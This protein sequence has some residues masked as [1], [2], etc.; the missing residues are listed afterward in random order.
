MMKNL[1]TYITGDVLVKGTAFLTLPLYS[2]L[3]MPSEYGVLGLLN[4]LVA[5]LPVVLTFGYINAFVRFFFESQERTIISTFVY[6]GLLLN[7]FY[8]LVSMI[9]YQLIVY[10]FDINLLHFMLKVL[11]S[12]VVFIFHILLL[13]YRSKSLASAFMKMTILYSVMGI[14]FSIVLLLQMKDNVL[15]IIIANLISGFI[16]SLV[17]YHKL[18]EQIYWRYVDWYL[19]KKILIYTTPLAIGAIG[20]LIFSQFDKIILG[21]YVSKKELGIYTMAFSVAIAVSYLGNAYLMAYQPV[22]FVNAK[23]NHGEIIKDYWR[24][25]AFILISL[26]VTFI[27][28]I[29]IYQLLDVGYLIGKKVSFMIAM[30]YTFLIFAQIMELHLSYAKKTVF[31]SIVFSFGGLMSYVGFIVLVPTYGIFGAAYSMLGSGFL[32]SVLMYIMA[33][34][35]LYLPYNKN[36]LVLFYAVMFFC[37]MLVCEFL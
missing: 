20:L 26:F 11:A 30:A 14:V 7:I 35:Y 29:I 2:Y 22:F 37:F 18:R 15:A 8:L 28:I 12:S 9:I 3:I 16:V 32:M 21:L 27:T 5:L 31:T 17:S 4:A 36:L 10:K 34:K 19:V 13:Y 33:Q 24:V 6:L 23:N 25:I 1:L